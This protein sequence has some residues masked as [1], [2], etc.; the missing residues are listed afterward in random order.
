[1]TMSD[2]YDALSY[3]VRR[4]IGWPQSW[5][6]D[7]RRWGSGQ[8]D[9]YRFL[10]ES[11]R[12]SA[13]QLLAYQ[14]QQ[15]AQLLDHA[16]HNTEFYRRRFD[17]LG[18]KPGD[19]RNFEDFR[20]LPVLTK[21]EVRAYTEELKSRKFEQLSPVETRTG[22]STGAPLFL[23]KSSRA[24]HM[25]VA[26]SW[27][28]RQW[29]G[30]DYRA[31]K[32]LIE[33][34][35][36]AMKQQPGW[37]LD[38]RSNSLLLWA[39]RLD[40]SRLDRYVKL[41]RRFKPQMLIGSIGFMRVFGRFLETTNEKRIRPRAVFVVGETVAPADRENVRRQFGCELFDAYGMRENAVSASE[42]KHHRL[43]INSEFTCV[44]F[45]PANDDSLSRRAAIIGTNLHN[46]AFPLIRYRTEDMG[47][48]HETECPCGM[49][50]PVMVI[51]GGRTRDFLRTREGHVFVSWHLAQFI[52]KRMGVRTMQLH[53]R[54]IDH[55]TV[56]IVRGPEFTANDEA[57]L[58]SSLN[59]L[60]G[61]LLQFRAEY[62][63]EI[64]RT[65][66]GKHLFVKSDLV[67]SLGELRT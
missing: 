40:D 56:R 52:D 28:S 47:Y 67:E 9:C 6:S 14:W 27:R 22:G 53:Q 31:L 49:A 45:E 19:I 35:H 37:Y 39:G 34:H 64:P 36:A 20:R 16:Y 65:A 8:I 62:V 3:A 23:Y 54:D 32:V 58:L 50:H 60:A 2:S 59:Q 57:Q 46:L 26:V 5:L 38:S 42:C 13:D 55:V 63:D 25:R 1:M 11:Q 18:A 41:C 30:V 4:A 61:D 15:L 17:D 7:E 21:D 12:W 24:E 29:A 66:L 51:E 44:E 43:H 48:A 10:L 33:I